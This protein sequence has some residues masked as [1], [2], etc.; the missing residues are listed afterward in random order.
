[1]SMEIREVNPD[2]A[3]MVE[4]LRDTGYKFNTA[5]ADVVDNSIA[6]EA[7]NVEVELRMSRSG[8]VTLKIFD[9]GIGMD[10]D[11]V[12]DAMRYGAKAR[13][14]RK[15]LGKFG[16]GL[17]TASTAFCRKL[18]IISRLD[19][20]ADLVRATWDLDRI[21][22]EGKWNLIIDS[23]TE[24]QTAEF[25]K[26]IPGGRGTMVAWEQ[27]DRLLKNYEIPGGGPAR[28]ALDKIV[29]GLKFHF[30]MVYQRFLDGSDDRERTLRLRL[31]GTEVS[32]W[33]PFCKGVSLMAKEETMPVEMG[34][35]TEAEFSIRAYVLPRKEEF[36]SEEA[37]KEARLTNAHQGI[38]VYRENRMIHGPTWLEMFSKEPHMTLLRIEF[39]FDYRLDEA[40]QIDIKKSQILL[41]EGLHQHVL[42]F[43]TPVRRAAED[44]YRTGRRKITHKNAAGAHDVSNR[45]IASKSDGINQPTV[46]GTDEAKGEITL[47]NSQG[48]VR[49][50]LKVSAAASPAEIFVQTVESIED[51]LLWKPALIQGDDGK[52]HLGVQIN[53]G[54]PYYAKVYLPNLSE[55][56]TVQGM[57]AL[58]WGMC[59]AE[60]NCVSDG[61]KRMF[62][63][64][65]FEVSR[66]LK[67]L[68]ED[69]PEAK[70]EE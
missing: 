21:K 62:E 5:V 41:D 3:R 10:R 28:K 1:M 57:D 46:T 13:V 9:D 22:T 15:S 36:A 48:T 52:Q 14:S 70:I 49:L 24:E 33:D 68:V 37:K 2:P 45:N 63:D 18:S 20:G 32:A 29:E 47:S 8:A 56:V 64:M 51:G 7:T 38:Y 42:D 61:N 25:A 44:S 60:L 4:G 19:P 40:F 27:V 50:K 67:K 12:V 55:G 31:N 59:I 35:G 43:I 69:L 65:R 34:D 30:A 6:A 53:T 66:N 58:L 17:K 54:H 16:L 23:P 39:S 26:F 11:G